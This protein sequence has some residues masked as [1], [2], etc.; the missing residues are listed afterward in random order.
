MT[1]DGLTDR[2][3]ACHD[4]SLDAWNDHD[5]ER[6]VAQFVDG[7]TYV[8]P[9]FDEPIA[10]EAIAEFVR[11]TAGRF[12]DFRFEQRRA[13]DVPDESARI[14]EWTM[15]GTHRG[16]RDGLPPTGNTIALDGASVVEFAPDGVRSSRGYFDQQ[17]LAEQLGL[18]FPAVLGQ[19]P[20]MT[21]GAVKEVL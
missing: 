21:V 12:P 14:E 15:H 17:E 5:P 3:V 9:L 19:L 2:Q 6:A 20:T 7:G 8:D 11:L 1:G 16:M 4:A 13:L 18:T 10:G